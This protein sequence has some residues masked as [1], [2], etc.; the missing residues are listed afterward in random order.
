MSTDGK[1][2]TKE[3]IAD[4]MGMYYD[5]MDEKELLEAR[6][7]I[8]MEERDAIRRDYDKLRKT[9][10]RCVFSNIRRA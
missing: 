9:L 7:K 8:C 1:E 10:R 5:M 4:V 2:T 6:L 3:D